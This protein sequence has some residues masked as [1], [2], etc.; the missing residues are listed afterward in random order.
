MSESQAPPEGDL[1]FRQMLVGQMQNLAYLV[2]SR[3]SR[4]ALIVDPA[5]AVVPTVVSRASA[6]YLV[7]VDPD[8]RHDRW[9]TPYTQS[10]KRA[11]KP[12]VHPLASQKRGS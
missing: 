8:Y 9:S 5:W 10:G 4:Q 1:Y 12:F 3:S 7:P 11:N 6:G 2:G